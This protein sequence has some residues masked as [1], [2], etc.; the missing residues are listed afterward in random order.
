[1]RKAAISAAIFLSSPLLRRGATKAD[2]H[3]RYF[4]NKKM[5]QKPLIHFEQ[6]LAT[7]IYLDFLLRSPAAPNT[8]RVK[9]AELYFV[10]GSWLIVNR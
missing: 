10:N 2:F 1:L 9:I 4:A 7:L 5:F 6:A 8:K 3:D